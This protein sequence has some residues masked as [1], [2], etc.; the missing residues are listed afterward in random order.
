MPG[1]FRLRLGLPLGVQLVC[2]LKKAAGG[3]GGLGVWVACGPTGLFGGRE[4][5]ILYTVHH[6]RL[7]KCLRELP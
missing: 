7:K 5:Q 3:L 2:D 4:S 1:I 6:C